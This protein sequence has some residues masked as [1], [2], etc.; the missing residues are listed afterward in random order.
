[1]VTSILLVPMVLLEFLAWVG[2]STQH[3]L[4]EA[5]VFA[6]TALFAAYGA[7]RA[8]V[9][10]AALLAG[11]AL[12]VAWLDVWEAILGSPRWRLPGAIHRAADRLGNTI[13]SLYLGMVRRRS[14]SRGS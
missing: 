11:L 7:R 14:R 4:Y 3:S 13:V 12:L 9:S 2:A 1:M 10:Y 6:V 8:R 5:A